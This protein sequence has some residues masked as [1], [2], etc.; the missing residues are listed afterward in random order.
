[1]P[2]ETADALGEIAVIGLACRFPGA[3]DAQAFWD[4]LRR[5]VESIS[6]FTDEELAAIPPEL[7][8]DPSYVKAC[9]VVDGIDL[10]D[11]EFFGLSP[12]EA[13]IADPQQ[14]LFFECGWQALED[15]GYDPE[16]HG[17]A[18]GV[19]A[20]ASTSLY[21]DHLLADPAVRE[22]AGHV[23]LSIGNDK[24][25]LAPRLS[26]LLN[27]KGPSVP[28]Q[29]ACSTSLVA[30]HFAC[31]SLLHF[32]CDL[33]LAGGCTILVPKKTGYLYLEGGTHSPDGH[34]RAF[35]AAA[36]GTAQGSG[37]GLVVLKRLD[38]AIADGDAVR[39]VIRG[40]AINN[41][42]A[43]KVGYTAPS[44]E[45]QRRVVQEAQAVAEVEPSEV[46]Y[47][48]AHGTG[49][50]LGDP[51]EVEA[52]RQ[53]FGE[54]VPNASC[55]LGSVKT[56][57]GHADSAAGIAGLIKTILCLE[58]R[59]LVPSLNFE[60]PNPALDLDRGPF[61]VNTE[62]VPW[63]RTPR[64]AGVSAFA[65]GGTN[66]HAVLAE[67]P[68]GAPSGAS[69]PVQLI[70]L[71]A[72]TRTALDAV[73]ADLQGHLEG[74]PDTPLADV[75]FTLAAGRRSFPVRDAFVCRDRDEAL[76]LLGRERPAA[77]LDEGAS[78]S[79][80]F[81]FPGQ[82]KAYAN[83]GR[84]L[85]E[86]ER[87]FREAADTCC[88]LLR[89][90]LDA[91]L[92][93]LLFAGGDRAELERPSR[94]QPALAVVEL[95]L[96]RLWRSWGVTPAAVIGHSIG[97]VVAAAE[98]GVL[99]LGDALRL[100]A[101]RGRLTEEVPPGAMLAVAAAEETLRPW[102]EAPVSLAAVNGPELCVLS[103]PVAEIER[104]GSELAERHPIR[105]ET[106]HAFHS[107]M[108]EPLA[109]PLTE[110]A[111][112]FERRA[113][114]VP[115]VSNVTGT[116]MSAEDAADPGYWAR[117]LLSPVR[118]FAG[119]ETLLAEPGR[120]LIEV[121]PGRV[122]SRMV[123]RSG[124]RVPA[125]PS[126]ASAE[127]DDP[128]ARQGRPDRGDGDQAAVLGAL[129]AA[130]CA[131]LTVDWQAVYAG[132][133]RRRIPLPTYPFE[134]RSFWVDERPPARR[135]APALETRAP[136]EAWLWAPGWKQAPLAVAPRLAERFE[137]GGRWLVL[138]RGDAF[139]EDLVRRLEE[140]GQT[141]VQVLEGPRFSS[142]G[143]GRF[144]LDPSDPRGYDELFAHLGAEGLPPRVVHAW[145]TEAE[146]TSAE[147]LDADL[148]RGFHGLIRLA[149]QL[150]ARGEPQSGGKIGLTVVSHRA[151]GVLGA[152][153]APEKA[154]LT[155]AVQVVPR[156]LSSLACRGVDF[157][158]DEDPGAL[159][160]LLLAE[161][162]L[163]EGADVA[164]R[165][166]L[167]W[168]PSFEP[169]AVG[170]SAPRPLEAG[171]YLVTNALQ[172][173]G[174][175]LA[176]RLARTDGVRVVLVDR[177]FVPP[178]VEWDAWIAD[179]GPEDFLSRKLERLRRLGDPVEVLTAN[180]ADRRAM[181][182]VRQHVAERH[183]GLRGVFHLDRPSETGLILGKS[184]N[185]PG[186]ALSSKIREALV[187]EA[188]FGD[189]PFTVLFSS[190]GAE[191]G[192][193]G[194]AEQAAAYAFLGAHAAHRTAAGS[195][196]LAIDWGTPRWDPEEGG[197][198]GE[199]FI[200]RQLAEKRRRFGMTVEE[201]LETL[202]RALGLALPHVIVSTRD[203]PLLLEQQHEFT[204]DYFQQRMREESGA[205]PDGEAGGADA[206]FP[207]PE[208]S[209]PYVPPGDEVETLL[210]E[211]WQAFFG[212]REIG[213]HDN[214]FELGGH[215]L[216]AV[217]LLNRLNETFSV[218]LTLKAFFD[219]PT[220]SALA[221]AVAQAQLGEE[222][223][224]TLDRL[225]A[226]IEGLSENEVRTALDAPS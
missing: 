217:Q 155:G 22:A 35:D 89:P 201:H 162:A 177:A 88:E 199:S 79:A 200:Q 169:L 92:R 222:E 13:T 171:A 197:E 161:I 86:R 158:L 10:F 48:E 95:A 7:L 193:L 94:W 107:A 122:L 121:G 182:R 71:S 168:V 18:L 174:L 59:T 153:D 164:Y 160:E 49:T 146:P 170:E 41:D 176:E 218:R 81:L 16:T 204:A 145:R 100:V 27:L 19:F 167:R 23:Q 87:V 47:L 99:E 211:T 119:L 132:E 117:H 207:R 46:S 29:T 54:G 196:V 32:E 143:E 1:M 69:R 14:R 78:R 152:C 31:Q 128:H 118:F 37:V 90:H 33:A 53:A 43:A 137:A 109:A 189:A 34:C 159:V 116:W 175:A 157:D 163:G 9:G 76:R 219:A 131:G 125:I 187:L 84:G 30:V 126:L 214:F 188:L 70:T 51:I 220:I 181:E 63:E 17:E 223:A 45:G 57:I 97:E 215:S 166:G 206:L 58:H 73:R 42:G 98:A 50:T 36:N 60:R 110:L 112:T 103:G 120:V 26:Y 102:L 130:W 61:Y 25:H 85:Y 64:Y 12:R 138:H 148:D 226:E 178:P 111:A 105:L 151:R 203:Y 83:L 21:L 39:A 6:F 124:Q 108:M 140:L 144:S 65:I 180:P 20:G 66:A 208:L 192:G 142:D 190:N 55:A 179:Q 191:S 225:L 82:G 134:R 68:E 184:A 154:S 135:E 4:N 205:G 114:E 209:E 101:E 224:E 198:L 72:R 149:Q 74:H 96:A 213:I 28:V 11:A 3:G 38:E 56:N 106:R 44:V 93:E 62:T 212:I 5:G 156:E 221:T 216:L 67:A 127:V 52:L 113:P 185:D 91:D 150:A 104:L 24:D 147:R 141:V 123:E 136:S 133:R 172:E 40:T 77:R 173:L 15:A 8:E 2:E 186:P 202:E 195:R 165:R 129:G 183:G 75:A 115:L 210:A 139:G 80:V 194:Q